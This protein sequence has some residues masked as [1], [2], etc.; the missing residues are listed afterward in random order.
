MSSNTDVIYEVDD[1]IAII[2]LNRP[3]KLNAFT[4]ETLAQLRQAVHKA[5]HDR[6]VVG[7]VITGEGRGFCAGL[8]AEVLEATAR[9]ATSRPTEEPGEEIPGLFTY[10]WAVEKPIIAAVNG[11]AA[12]GGFVLAS[13]CDVRFASADASFITVFSKRGLISEHGTSW[14]VPRLVGT[15]AALDLLWSSRKVE[16]D[17]AYRLGL[18]EYLCEPENLLED[19]CNYVRQLAATVSPRSIAHTKRLVYRHSGSMFEQALREADVTQWE[20]LSHADA[21]EGV[22]SYVEQ[23]APRFE[24][25]GDDDS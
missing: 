6:R 10:L 25:L 1:P 15:G 16:A 13:L 19:A 2:R 7:I 12:G 4:H 21:V 14:I 9:G 18:V 8:D 22:R 24:R 20:A 11:V 17:E 23:R 5:Q 3:E